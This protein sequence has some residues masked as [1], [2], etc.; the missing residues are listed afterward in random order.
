MDALMSYGLL[1]LS[2][3]LPGLGVAKGILK[4][5]PEFNSWEVGVLILLS[6]LGV[7]SLVCFTA[8]VCGVFDVQLIWGILLTFA[9]VSF[10]T[11][12]VSSSG[13]ASPSVWRRLF[14]RPQPLLLGV[15]LIMLAILFQPKPGEWLTNYHMDAGRYSNIASLLLLTEG[16]EIKNSL[17]EESAGLQPKVDVA[18]FPS[19]FR[20]KQRPDFVYVGPYVHLYPALLA[21]VRAHIG[22]YQSLRLNQVLG[23]LS[24]CAFFLL[25]K[26]C[27]RP[28]MRST[29]SS[30][31]S[32]TT[33]LT[34]LSLGGAILL[35]SNPASQLCFNRN[36]TEALAQVLTLFGFISLYLLERSR[37]VFLAF[38]SACIFFLLP[39]CRVEFGLLYP[40]LPLIYLFLS[41]GRKP[42]RSLVMFLLFSLLFFIPL[43]WYYN[44]TAYTYVLLN[45]KKA[46]R[47]LWHLYTNNFEEIRPWFVLAWLGFNM[48]LLVLTTG[49]VV[50]RERYVRLKFFQIFQNERVLSILVTGSYAAFLAW[51]LFVRP[52]GG[53]PADSG[54]GRGYNHDTINLLRLLHFQDILTLC[55]GV[56]G[57]WALFQKASYRSYGI[58]VLVLTVVFLIKSSHSSPVLWWIRR[59]VPVTVPGLYYFSVLALS[60]LP[61]RFAW[62]AFTVALSFNITGTIMTVRGY[63]EKEGLYQYYE[64]LAQHFKSDPLAQAETQAIQLC[65]TGDTCNHAAV[66]LQAYFGIPTLYLTPGL[67]DVKIAFLKNLLRAKRRVFVTYSALDLA[68][69]PADDLV[70]LQQAELQLQLV[71]DS[72]FVSSDVWGLEGWSAG[73]D[74]RELYVPGSLQGARFRDQQ[75]PVKIYE[76][77]SLT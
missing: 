7:V 15:G 29:I 30:K 39:V 73:E 58:F 3:V 59:Y 10:F 4:H 28:M 21:F 27:L 12:S 66:P 8:A 67:S 54:Y 45:S 53:P 64:S 26:L 57:V 20:G 70:K 6:S 69:F 48:F 19:F 17:G 65:F 77:I 16:L 37:S 33:S 52:V 18:D 25:L 56:F 60:F 42:D 76:I 24:A 34:F 9:T 49:L 72:T 38:V 22:T 63:T 31:I 43:A 74:W 36:M 11:V 68:P 1:F 71:R 50:A 75:F 47:P 13:V 41:W 32:S 40:V 44:N 61:R 2:L 55:L 14:D 51:N 23:I 46:L 62:F 5:C 35:Y